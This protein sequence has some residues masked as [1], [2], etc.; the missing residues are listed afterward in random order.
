MARPPCQAG[1][2]RLAVVKRS[3]IG[4]SHGDS[5]VVLVGGVSFC[6]ALVVMQL[7]IMFVDSCGLGA[8]LVCS[9]AS[10]GSQDVRQPLVGDLNPWFL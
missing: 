6:F 10:I 2:E 4:V 9:L 3:Q 7:F 8:G 5:C 1:E